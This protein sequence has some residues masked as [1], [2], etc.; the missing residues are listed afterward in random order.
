MRFV[1]TEQAV[2]WQGEEVW[3]PRVYVEDGE[4]RRRRAGREEWEAWW[5]FVEG[6]EGEGEKEELKIG[7]AVVRRVF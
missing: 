3:V 5:G 6:R 2:W 7:E 4:G 1:A